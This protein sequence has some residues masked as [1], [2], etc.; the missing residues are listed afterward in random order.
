MII[1]IR[2]FDSLSL[3]S[4]SLD[5]VYV[6]I[7]DGEETWHIGATDD[8][9]GTIFIIAPVYMLLLLVLENIV[10]FCPFFSIYM[11]FETKVY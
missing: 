8:A 7:L 4:S 1:V 11:V 2:S 6:S 3:F 5:I 10:E 9:K